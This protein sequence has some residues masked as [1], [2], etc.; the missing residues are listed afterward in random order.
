M[1]E[2][3]FSTNLEYYKSFYYVVKY[4]TITAAADCLCLTQ[5]TVTSAIQKLEEQL[6]CTLFLR[7]KRGMTLT[8]EGKIL[9]DRVEPACQLLLSAERELAAAQ[10]LDGGNLSIASTEMSFRT[11]VLPAMERFTR[12][13]PNV[14][15]RFRNAPLS[16][17]ILDMIRNGE[18]DLAI[19]HAPFQAGEHLQTRLIGT[20]EEC[21]VAGPKYAFLADA[22]RPVPEPLQYPFVSVPAG[23]PTQP[24]VRGTFQRYGL[25]YEP[26]ME[27]TTSELVIQAVKHNLG[28][29][30]LPWQR[31]RKDVDRGELFRIDIGGPPMERKAYLI[32]HGE[33]P[34][35]PAARAFVDQYLPAPPEREEKAAPKG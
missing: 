6:G 34:L 7:T 11:Y 15:V 33:I 20:I 35:G 3:S 18:I 14:K 28:L 32:T 4:G 27:V 19:L 10:K 16:D 31:I 8:A 12:D 30:M 24:S 17:K 29:A 5:P 2:R 9:W 23:P 21:F 13:H 25:D 22:P 26:E 1:D